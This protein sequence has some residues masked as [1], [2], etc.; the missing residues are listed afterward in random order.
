MIDRVSPRKMS[1]L[2]VTCVVGCTAAALVLMTASCSPSSTEV[3]ATSGGAAPVDAPTVDATPLGSTVQIEDG[4]TTYAVTVENF[5]P[6]V[7]F[8]YG[9]PATGQLMQ[10]EV[11]IQ[12]I[13]GS[14]NI[15]PLYVSARAADGT[16]YDAA[17]G[18]T[19]GQLSVTTLGAGDVIKGSVPFDVT[20]SPIAT[21]RWSGPLLDN[22]ATWTV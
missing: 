5:E 9:L 4:G 8:E 22:L 13:A 11:T 10:V 15:N 3:V 20:G 12:G 2:F 1:G 7:P 18:T 17:I 6:A 21:I 14:T 16:S 19:D